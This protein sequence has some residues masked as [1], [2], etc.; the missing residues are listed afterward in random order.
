MNHLK[1]YRGLFQVPAL[2]HGEAHRNL[3]LV[4]V[5]DFVVL[6][7]AFRGSAAMLCGYRMREIPFDEGAAGNEWHI[8]EINDLTMS[9]LMRWI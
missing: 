5:A 6:Y 4:F 3:S 7:V 2:V 9:G 1:L 8:V